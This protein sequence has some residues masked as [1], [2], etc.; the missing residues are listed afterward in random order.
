MSQ[1]RARELDYLSSSTYSDWLG[2]AAGGDVNSQALLALGSYRPSRFQKPLCHPPTKRR[3]WQLGMKELRAPMCTKMA[4]D[5]ERIERRPEAPG[6]VQ[7][8]VFLSPSLAQSLA[9]ITG[10]LQ[11]QYSEPHGVLMQG[12]FPSSLRLAHH[13]ATW[14][15]DLSDL[16]GMS[17]KASFRNCFLPLFLLQ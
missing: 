6:T 12:F 16:N 8:P 15:R 4:K 2:A 10:R 14:L 9:M 1:S 7:R 3:G 13:Q 17:Y 11:L 5:S